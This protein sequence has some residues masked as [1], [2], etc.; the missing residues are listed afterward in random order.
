VK[1]PI[2]LICHAIVIPTVCS[3]L[4]KPPLQH[5][6]NLQQL[7]CGMTQVSDLWRSKWANR[8]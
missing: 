7:A 2:A 5:L 6:A 1:L 3:H 4:C 8:S